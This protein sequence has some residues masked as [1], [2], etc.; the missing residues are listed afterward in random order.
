MGSDLAV[1]F[2]CV[3]L[4]GV[5]S[6]RIGGFFDDVEVSNPAVTLGAAPLTLATMGGWI[7]LMF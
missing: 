5:I 7:S 4:S 1:C 6:M 2:R 3:Q